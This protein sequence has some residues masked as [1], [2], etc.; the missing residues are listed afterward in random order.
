[1]H[2]AESLHGSELRTQSVE[3]SRLTIK[4]DPVLILLRNIW[5]H[6]AP[7]VGTIAYT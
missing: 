5:V 1:M 7:V 4:I 2:N 6:I 3:G